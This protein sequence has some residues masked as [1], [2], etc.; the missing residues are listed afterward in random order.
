MKNL[1]YSDFCLSLH[2]LAQV[3]L[4]KMGCSTMG[5]S[6]TLV[7]TILYI[8]CIKE[9]KTSAY[10]YL[11]NIFGIGSYKQDAGVCSAEGFST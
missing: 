6:I 9:N 8:F 2:H 4:V 5:L 3:L 11:A 10:L 1:Y 7:H